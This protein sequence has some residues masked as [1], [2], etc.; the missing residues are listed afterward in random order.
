[1]GY[2]AITN[3]AVLLI[4]S[5]LD[6]VV[7]RRRAEGFSLPAKDVPHT[8][9]RVA[10]PRNL[11]AWQGERLFDNLDSGQYGYEVVDIVGSPS[12]HA[13]VLR[14]CMSASSSVRAAPEYRG[15]ARHCRHPIAERNRLRGRV[16]TNM[17]SQ[18]RH[19]MSVIHS[20]PYLR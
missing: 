4:P 1:L 6:S 17:T 18:R 12:S 16:I 8:K 9:I 15:L 19:D 5:V 14:G 7:I 2:K 11:R 13:S 10:S 3:M 20:C